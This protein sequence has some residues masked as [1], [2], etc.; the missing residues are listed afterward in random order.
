MIRFIPF[1][2]HWIFY[3]LWG[4]VYALVEV[5]FNSQTTVRDRKTGKN[6]AGPPDLVGGLIVGLTHFVAVTIVWYAVSRGL[7]LKVDDGTGP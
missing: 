4:P 1:L 3:V 2:Q 6:V 7:V 5:W